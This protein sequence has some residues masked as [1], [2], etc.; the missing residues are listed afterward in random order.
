MVEVLAFGGKG[1]GWKGVPWMVEGRE[2]DSVGGGMKLVFVIICFRVRKKI[3]KRRKRKAKVGT[4]RIEKG[5]ICEF[6]IYDSRFEA[7][8]FQ[9]FLVL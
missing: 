1:A 8:P 7:N 4:K 9:V 2:K 6:Y 3:E 5:N